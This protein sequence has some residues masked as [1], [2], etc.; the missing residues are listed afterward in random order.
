MTVQELIDKLSA[1]KDSEKN[2]EI[3]YDDFAVHGLHYTQTFDPFSGAK[4]EFVEMW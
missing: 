1:L 2:L 4:I 3:L